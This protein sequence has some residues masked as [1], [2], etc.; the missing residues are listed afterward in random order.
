[1]VD[2]AHQHDFSNGDNDDHGRQKKGGRSNV[3]VRRRRCSDLT[4]NF[5]R[6]IGGVCDQQQ[7][8]A[9]QRVLCNGSDLS[10]KWKLVWLVPCVHASSGVLRWQHKHTYHMFSRQGKWNSIH[11]VNYAVCPDTAA[12]VRSSFRPR[13]RRL[14]RCND[15]IRIHYLVCARTR[16]SLV[17]FYMFSLVW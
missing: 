5:H 3:D 6:I 2:V 17:L 7:D 13:A 4:R 14:S 8:S 11:V 1:M 9:R 12:Y 15:D 10:K 16:T